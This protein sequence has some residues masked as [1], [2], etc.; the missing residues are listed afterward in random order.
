MSGAQAAGGIK[1]TS[2]CACSLGRCRQLS[3][4][5]P[6]WKQSRASTHTATRGG[7]S[8]LS[9]PES[10]HPSSNVPLGPRD[11]LWLEHL[12]GVVTGELGFARGRRIWPELSVL[13]PSPRSAPARPTPG[14]HLRR[15]FLVLP[16]FAILFKKPG[17]LY[18]FFKDITDFTNSI[19]QINL[20]FYK[21]LQPTRV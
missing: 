9:A 18:F 10:P 11:S 20:T 16:P 12:G 13:G 7:F 14:P 6:A 19:N 2:E 21:S 15:G 4:Q 8:G 1:A 5:E 17:F 3:G